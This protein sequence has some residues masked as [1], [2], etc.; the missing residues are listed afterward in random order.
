MTDRERWIVYPLVF[1]TLGIA[2]RNQFLPTRRFG[3][4]DL[5]AG[6]VAAQKIICNDLVVQQR[7]ECSQLQCEQFK[8]NEALGKHISTLGLAECLQLKAVEAE[9]RALFIA[10]AEGRPVIVAGADKDSQCGIIQ[11]MNRNGRPVFVAG[12]DKDSQ[13]GIIRTMNRNG[14]PMVKVY[15]TETG[16]A[17]STVGLGG[18]VWVEMGQEGQNVGV[19]AKLPQIGQIVP[20]TSPWPVAPQARTPKPSQ[21]PAPA[22]PQQPGNQPGDGNTP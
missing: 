5:R 9:C 3:A 16:G 7:E 14:M 13:S 20:L 11:T 18:Q 2:L 6:E 19:F 1:L 22:A 10:D 4:V 8:F 12:A 21:S 17:I 15:S